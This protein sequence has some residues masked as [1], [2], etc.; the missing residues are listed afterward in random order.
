MCYLLRH[1]V[2]IIKEESFNI[3][4]NTYDFGSAK[5]LYFGNLKTSVLSVTDLTNTVVITTCRFPE[6][7]SRASPIDRRYV[8]IEQF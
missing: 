8:A 1:A 7:G 6:T 5:T 2:H 4:L 3:F